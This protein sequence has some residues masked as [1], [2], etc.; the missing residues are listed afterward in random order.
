MRTGIPSPGSHNRIIFSS[1]E[2][3]RALES[4]WRGCWTCEFISR[5][6]KNYAISDEKLTGPSYA[7]FVFRH[8]NIVIK[9][10]IFYFCQASNMRSLI[11]RLLFF[12]SFVVS[13]EQSDSHRFRFHRISF[14]RHGCEPQSHRNTSRYPR[15]KKSYL[16]NCKFYRLSLI[17]ISEPT[18]PY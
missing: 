14:S 4:R 18:R 6:E 1:L 3:G 11:C 12:D 7:R 17:H 8:R 2:F 10:V 13:L 5:V 16:Q 15:A 9:N